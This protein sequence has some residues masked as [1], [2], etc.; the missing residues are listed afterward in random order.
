MKRLHMIAIAA[1]LAAPASVL[2]QAP[3]ERIQVPAER[4]IV[5]DLPSYQAFVARTGGAL[6]S[7]GA[8][9]EDTILA[10]NVAMAMAQDPYLKDVSVTVSAHKGRVTISG[11]GNQAEMYHAQKV[12]KRVAGNVTGQLASDHG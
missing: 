9:L 12:A 3:V 8:N 7:G 1:A 2:A 6:Q 10:D 4:V 11:Q 5:Y